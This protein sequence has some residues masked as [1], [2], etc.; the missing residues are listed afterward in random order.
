VAGLF[1]EAG[2]EAHTVDADHAESLLWGKLAVNCGINALTALLRVPNGELLNRPDAAALMAAAAEECAAVA[3]AKGIP[4]PYAPGVTAADQ[5]RWVAE[6]T[7]VN[8][9]SMFQ[10]ILRGAPTEVDAINGAVA[11]AG[12]RLGVPVAVNA[13]L[14]RLVRALA[15]A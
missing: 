15:P 12:E 10:D 1:R 5:A 6:H 8:H 7:K 11:Q 14:W 4:L 13:T 9:S 3:R 2:L